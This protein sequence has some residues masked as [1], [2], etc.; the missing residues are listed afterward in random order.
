MTDKPDNMDSATLFISDAE[1]C[2]RLGV[3][4]KTA[5]KAI[6]ALE[7]HQNFPPRDNLFA[8]K[9]YWP[10]VKAFLDQRGRLS[11]APDNKTWT[12]NFDE[13]PKDRK[14]AGAGMEKAR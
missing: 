5:G 13:P 14:R 8:G 1:L 9:R 7:Q 2:R 4:P 3:S 11:I 10:A 12:E 6:A